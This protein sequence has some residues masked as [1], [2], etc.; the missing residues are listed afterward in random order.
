[1]YGLLKKIYERLNMDAINNVY[2][3]R[4]PIY[5]QREFINEIAPPQNEYQQS[6]FKYK[7]FCESCYY[8]R[9]WILMI[10]NIGAFLIYPLMYRKLYKKGRNMQRS[11]SDIDAVVQN[12]PRLRNEDILPKEI[13]EQYKNIIEIESINYKDIYLN[14]KAVE[15]CNELEKRYFLEPYFRIIVMIKLALFSRYIEEYN[16][17]A[18]IFYACEREF[19]GPLQT[20]LCEQEGISYESFM[21]GDYLYDIC[22]AF[23]KF[24]KYYIWDEA[25]LKLFDSLR[26]SFPMYI[27]KPAKLESIARVLDEHRCKYFATYYFSNETRESIEIIHVIFK[28]LKEIGLRCK[29]RPHP[30]FSNLPVIKKIFI[31]FDIDDILSYSLARSIEDSL[32]IIG[33]NTT[34]LSQAYFSNKKIVIDDMSMKS[35]Y[36]NLKEKKYIMLTRKHELL[37]RFIETVKNANHYDKTFDFFV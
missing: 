19:S 3:E 29:V 17:K 20:Y 5:E 22:F 12:V 16:P 7:C 33:L 10:Y 27:Y 9:K 23:Q 15:I 8:K 4:M 34:V 21:H 18:I 24:S 35:K 30:R 36:L 2:Y 32:Y 26:C 11:T 28:K 1:M 37:S 25:Y 14:R 31:D 13:K 6:F